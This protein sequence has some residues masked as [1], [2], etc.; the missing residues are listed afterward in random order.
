MKRSIAI[1]ATMAITSLAI[2]DNAQAQ[3]QQ[4]DIIGKSTITIDGGLMTPE[5]L[6][7]MGRINSVHPDEQSG[8]IAY[9]ISYYSVEENRSTSWIRVCQH[10][11]SPIAN[12]QSPNNLIT[13]TLTLHTAGVAGVYIVDVILRDGSTEQTQVIIP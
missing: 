1:M 2:S 11:Q 8:R 6:W 9:T 7:A 10:A 5:A 4:T 12:S 3:V 13:N